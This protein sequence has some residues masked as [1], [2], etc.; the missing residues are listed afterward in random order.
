MSR[1]CLYDQRGLGPGDRTRVVWGG[2]GL[3]GGEG[4][5]Q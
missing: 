4:I 2:G 3:E 1:G 5:C